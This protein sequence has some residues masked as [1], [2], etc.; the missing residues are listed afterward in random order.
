MAYIDPGAG[1]LLLQ[2]LIAGC[3]GGVVFLRN[4]IFGW[5]AWFK[6]KAFPPKS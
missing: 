4:Q 3:V 2:F 6:Q 5:F 1:S